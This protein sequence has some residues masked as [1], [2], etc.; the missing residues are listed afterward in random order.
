MIRN[1]KNSHDHLHLL[2]FFN[3]RNSYAFGNVYALFYNELHYYTVLLYRDTEV[4]AFDVIQDVFSNIW[5]HE[6]IQ[7]GSLDG[8]KAYLYKSIRNSFNNY[9]TKKAVV[10][11]YE[12]ELRNNEDAVMV[13]IIESETYSLAEYVLGILPTDCAEIFRLVFEGWSIDEIAEK[14]GK[15]KQTIYNKKHETVKFLRDKISN[16]KLLFIATILGI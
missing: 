9:I 3:S 5:I 13:E 2:K 12:S 1:D 14:L 4:D 11:R 15:G 6:D 16:D 8:V 7:F 10:H